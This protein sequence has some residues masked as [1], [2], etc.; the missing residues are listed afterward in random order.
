MSKLSNHHLCWA[1]DA[2]TSRKQLLY[3]SQIGV[4]LN[5]NSIRQEIFK[6]WKL[7]KGI[8]ILLWAVIKK[9]NL[10]KG[11]KKEM[12]GRKNKASSN[13]EN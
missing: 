2:D 4:H 8:Q 12:T 5:S 9:I 7:F 13:S 10:Q 3:K 11:N 6:S 1:Y